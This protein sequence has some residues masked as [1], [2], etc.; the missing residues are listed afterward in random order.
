[1]SEGNRRGGEPPSQKG[2]EA[3]D[4]AGPTGLRS[5]SGFSAS[6]RARTLFFKAAAGIAEPC[7]FHV[8]GVIFVECAPQYWAQRTPAKKICWS[9]VITPQS[10]RLL[11]PGCF[12][13][14]PNSSAGH[15]Q[16]IVRPWDLAE[17]VAVCAK[18]PPPPKNAAAAVYVG[19]CN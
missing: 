1:M 7:S 4:H 19:G 10:S 17:S 12:L 3:R 8:R 15:A 6:S 5:E 18:T 2:P 14:W 9:S 13:L 16:M 11:F